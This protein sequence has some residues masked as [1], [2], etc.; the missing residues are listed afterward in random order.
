MKS[1]RERILQAAAIP[2]RWN[3]GRLE[4]AM[5]TR[6]QSSRWTVPKGHIEPGETPRQ[7]ALREALEEAGLLGRIGLR[8][9]GTYEYEKG[10]EPRLVVAYPM[11]VTRQLARWSEDF[12]S[13]EWIRP[14]RAVDRAPEQGLRDLLRRLAERLSA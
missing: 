10:S 1:T 12:R 2:Y 13:R 4:I 6:R 8:P 14:E 5:V 9:L 11:R 7:S 3:A